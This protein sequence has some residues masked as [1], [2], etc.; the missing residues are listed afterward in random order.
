MSPSQASAFGIPLAVGPV[1]AGQKRTSRCKVRDRR[2]ELTANMP[3]RQVTRQKHCILLAKLFRRIGGIGAA[4]YVIGLRYLHRRQA[5]EQSTANNANRPAP[6]PPSQPRPGRHETPRRHDRVDPGDSRLG[7]QTPGARGR[8]RPI[9]RAETSA[10]IR[11]HRLPA[12][13]MESLPSLSGGAAT[14]AIEP[15]PHGIAPPKRRASPGSPACFLAP[16]CLCGSPFARPRVRSCREFQMRLPEWSKPRGASCAH[17]RPAPHE[18][19]L[20][21]P[22]IGPAPDQSAGAP[23]L[24]LLMMEQFSEIAIVYKGRFCYRHVWLVRATSA[25][26]SAGA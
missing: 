10:C 20:Y 24:R 1:T 12:F 13:A 7:I 2:P 19:V 14:P 5:K 16:W 21:D 25:H 17:L 8:R 3:S 4:D 9:S 23:N 18:L 15:M 26:F 22:R 11:V 6:D